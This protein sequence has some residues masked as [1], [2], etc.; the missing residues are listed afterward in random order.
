[1]GS[2][3]LIVYG[4]WNGLQED[5]YPIDP[6]FKNFSGPGFIKLDG[7]SLFLDIKIV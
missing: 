5:F 4:D 6:Q 2:Y 3:P 1:M 7:A